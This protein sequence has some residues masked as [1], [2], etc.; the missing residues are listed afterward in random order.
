MSAPTPTFE[1]LAKD[2][3]AIADQVGSTTLDYATMN[4]TP[5]HDSRYSQQARN[6]MVTHGWSGTGGIGV[7]KQG[8]AEPV[9]TEIKSPRRRPLVGIATNEAHTETSGVQRCTGI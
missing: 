7:N 9:G 8:R 4:Q 2:F 1:A 3:Y 6:I 5:L